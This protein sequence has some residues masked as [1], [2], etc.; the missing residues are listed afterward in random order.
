MLGRTLTMLG[1]IAGSGAMA[2]GAR[3][4]FVC[5][6]VTACDALGACA[7]AEGSWQFTIE[8]VEVGPQGDG[9]YNMVYDQVL[10]QA[11]VRNDFT[12]IWEDDDWTFR[13]FIFTGSKTAIR[14]SRALQSPPMTL[15]EF[16]TCEGPS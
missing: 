13:E 6:V 7:P 4:H 12:M 11:V 9:L 16:L 3:Q 10:T 8:P 1:I 2:E 15:V 14:V 5:D